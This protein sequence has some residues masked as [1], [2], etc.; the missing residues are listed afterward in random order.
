MARKGAIPPPPADFDERAEN[1]ID[2]V[3]AN[4]RMVTLAVVVVLA[5]GV[6]VWL[7][8]RTQS[9]R[10]DRA[11]QVL[12]G[13]QEALAVNNVALAQA[14]LERLQTRYEGTRA[15]HNG[16]VLLAQVHFEQGRY[17]EG[18]QALD[19]Y[20]TRPPDYLTSAV[21][22][23]RAA[24]Y[25]QTG[26]GEMA[27][28]HYEAAAE[29]SRFDADRANY[30]ASAARLYMELGNRNRALE[31]WTDLAE[32][33]RGPMAAEARVRVGELRAAPAGAAGG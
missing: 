28:R 1:V 31:I 15:A 13:A 19:Q 3:K 30:L 8:V 7:Y 2:W 33:P 4:A 26:Q 25:E 20:A 5:V 21:E 18:L 6:G 23:L 9:I 24:G 17:A 14:D 11:E 10:Q 22:A 32:D 29:R 12:A 16:A 27:A